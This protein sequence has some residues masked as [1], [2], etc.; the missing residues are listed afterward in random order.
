[1]NA[2][3][4][5]ILSQ[6]QALR[7]A[8]QKTDL[9]TLTSLRAQLANG[10]FDRIV[11]T[12]MGA[13][14]YGM[15]PIW[16]R[17]AQ[18]SQPPI[19]VDA[20]ELIHHTPALIGERT[21]LWVVSQ[22]GRSAEI[23]H[24]LQLLEE[25]PP[26][27]LIILTNEPDSPLGQYAQSMPNKVLLPLYAEPEMTPSTRTYMNTLA[28][29][30]LAAVGLDLT[31]KVSLSDCLADLQR[32]ADGI[33]RYLQDWQVVLRSIESTFD[34]AART[35]PPSPPKIILLGRGPSLASA[36]VGALCLQEAAKIPALAFQS[37]QFRHGPLEIASPD[38]TVWVFAGSQEAPIYR[39]NR[40][41]WQ[42]LRQ[43]NLNAWL[44]QS[45]A[46]EKGCL[47][48]PDFSGI[49][50][51]LVEIVP[52]Q[53]LCYSICKQMGIEPGDFR[54]IGKVTEKE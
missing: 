50:L 3:L 40:K 12:G 38:L 52:V 21:L 49:G 7:L 8:L 29:G 15:Y 33:E 24:L 35:I 11:L 43:M 41:L 53:L 17:L 34:H 25:R 9:S 14:F 19:W 1:M 13:S 16:L 2:Y 27:G 39:L 31:A 18:S 46:N 48:L 42:D 4:A 54:H 26:A 44:L 47:S 20:A 51:P 22:S 5:D 37:G 10:C 23:I 36:L 45:S 32:A 30:Q 28:I 6:P